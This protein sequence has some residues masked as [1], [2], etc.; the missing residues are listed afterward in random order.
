MLQSSGKLRKSV[1]IEPSTY[2]AWVA[3]FFIESEISNSMK[4]SSE[5]A[6]CL[7]NPK[8]LDNGDVRKYI[9]E[10]LRSLKYILRNMETDF[11]SLSEEC[12][13]E[14]VSYSA[15]QSSKHD[16]VSVTIP[17]PEKLLT[18]RDFPDSKPSKKRK[19]EF[20]KTT[21]SSLMGTCDKTIL[22][23]G[24]SSVGICESVDFT[25]MKTM[26]YGKLRE[27]AFTQQVLLSH[28]DSWRLSVADILYSTLKNKWTLEEAVDLLEEGNMLLN[29]VN[30][31]E[32][33][34]LMVV[35]EKTRQFDDKV[36]QTFGL[37]PSETL[38]N[39]Y[40]KIRTSLKPSITELEKLLKEAQSCLLEGECI[41]FLHYQ[42]SQL[43]SWKLTVQAA[44]D[45]KN[46][47]K[48]KD[49]IK[50][51]DEI[52]I[53]VPGAED[54]AEQIAASNWIEKVERA[55][56]RPMRLNVAENLLNE[57]AARYLD[58]KKVVAKK[59]LIARVCRARSWLETVL[60]PPFIYNLVKVLK[61]APVN[62]ISDDIKVQL[63]KAREELEAFEKI[64]EEHKNREFTNTTG[65]ESLNEHLSKPKLPTPSEFEQ[66]WLESS[67]LK[68]TIPIM[69]YMEPIY[70]R[71]RKWL[72]KYRRVLDGV[73]TFMESQLVLEEAQYTLCEYLDMNEYVPI[74]LKKVGE[75]EEW[76]KSSREF[77]Q[78][79]TD[80]QIGKDVE[81]VT[82][83]I[84]STIGAIKKGGDLS[85]D[86]I[87]DL[88]DDV[89]TSRL[90]KPSLEQ[91]KVLIDRGHDLTIYDNN[92]QE[93]YSSLEY[94]DKWT[95][96]AKE[97][98]R[99]PRESTLTTNAIASLLLDCRNIQVCSETEITLISELK[100]N[101]W[102][103]DVRNLSCP[104]ED[105]KLEDLQR[106]LDSFLFRIEL[107]KSNFWINKNLAKSVKKKHNRRNR[108][109]DN[110]KDNEKPNIDE[111]IENF[112]F[113]N[114]QNSPIHAVED[115]EI[116]EN[117]SAKL[118]KENFDQTKINNS[119]IKV[120]SLINSEE[121]SVPL[122]EKLNFGEYLE[123]YI[124]EEELCGDSIKVENT[125]DLIDLGFNQVHISE[126]TTRDWSEI[127][128]LDE[129]QFFYKLRD[130]AAYWESEALKLANTEHKVPVNK[131]QDL[132]KNLE[133]RP[134]R[135]YKI[136]AKICEYLKEQE[137]VR[138]LLVYGD[139][140][141]NEAMQLPHP[142]SLFYSFEKLVKIKENIDKLPIVIDEW[143]KW[144]I[145]LE[146]LQEIDK[147]SILKFPYLELYKYK[148]DDNSSEISG[149]VTSLPE[150]TKNIDEDFHSRQF[151]SLV[152]VKKHLEDLEFDISWGF[153]NIEYPEKLL[154]SL[155]A[156]RYL[157]YDMN[158]TLDWIEVVTNPDTCK[159]LDEWKELLNKG[160]NLRI[161]D[162]LVM[163][164][165]ESQLLE[166]E[167]WLEL[168][169]M[170]LH[171]K[172]SQARN[173]TSLRSRRQ[174]VS[175]VT[176][177]VPVKFSLTNAKKLVKTSYGLGEKLLQFRNLKSDVKLA[178]NLKSESIKLLIDS[179][180]ERRTNKFS[181]I[182]KKHLKIRNK[183]DLENT[184]K[185]HHLSQ[186]ENLYNEVLELARLTKRMTCTLA[187]CS[188]QFIL[189]D[190]MSYLQDELL[191]REINHK[192]L[193]LLL[194]DEYPY[195]KSN[196]INQV[197]YE[198]PEVVAGL[199][200][201]GRRSGLPISSLSDAVDLLS[202]IDKQNLLVLSCSDTH[203]DETD[204]I[205]S[206]EDSST[207]CVD[208]SD[209]DLATLEELKESFNEHSSSEVSDLS[210]ETLSLIYQKESSY[211]DSFLARSLQESVNKAKRWLELYKSFNFVRIALS[212]N[213]T[214]KLGQM[215]V[216][217][218][219]IPESIVTLLPSLFSELFSS[220][221]TKLQLIWSSLFEKYD[222]LVFD[223]SPQF[224]FRDTIEK[225]KKDHISKSHAQD[226]GIEYNVSLWL[227][228]SYYM[229]S[230]ER[231]SQVPDFDKE[232][233]EL[234]CSKIYS[235]TISHVQHLYPEFN[236][237]L[238]N[239]QT[240]QLSN[241]SSGITVG[242]GNTHKRQRR[243]KS[244][245]G[246]E[247]KGHGVSLSYQDILNLKERHIP[248][249]QDAIFLLYFAKKTVTLEIP[250]LDKLCGIVENIIL[251]NFLIYK[252]FP[253]LRYVSN[254]DLNK[255]LG[256]K[257]PSSL[258][259]CKKELWEHSLLFKISN[260]DIVDFGNKN[261]TDIKK[262][263][264][265][266]N[267]EEIKEFPVKS[268]SEVIESDRDSLDISNFEDNI[269]KMN[270]FLNIWDTSQ[271]SNFLANP[272]GGQTANLDTL[273]ELIEACDHLPFQIPLK[274]RLVGIFLDTLSWCLDA[275][276]AILLL[277]KNTLV[278]PWEDIVGD[279][280]ELK[281]QCLESERIFESSILYMN[282]SDISDS[283]TLD[284]WDNFSNQL[285][286][287]N[288]EDVEQ[289]IN[290][291]TIQSY[292]DSYLNGR[293]EDNNK[294]ENLIDYS[295]KRFSRPRGR[296][297]RLAN[298]N[299]KKISTLVHSDE[300]TSTSSLSKDKFSY[301]VCGRSLEESEIFPKSF[302][303]WL[304]KNPN[305]TFTIEDFMA[306]TL[307]QDTDK[308]RS[309]NK[310]GPTT[311]SNSHSIR[312]TLQGWR[313]GYFFS[314]RKKDPEINVMTDRNIDYSLY[315]QQV[316]MLDPNC[317]PKFHEY[318]NNSLIVYFIICMELYRSIQRTPADLCSICASF[319]DESLSS[320]SSSSWIACDECNRWYHQTCVGFI[321]LL[322][323]TD[324]NEDQNLRS[325]REFIAE[326]EDTEIETEKNLTSSININISWVCP[327][328]NLR[329]ISPNKVTPII[330]FLKNSEN[331][332][333]NHNSIYTFNS[334]SATE[335][336]AKEWSVEREVPKFERF[337][338]LLKESW[339]GSTRLINLYE[340][341]MILNRVTL[342]MLWMRDFYTKTR[343][344][345]F[346]NS[347]FDWSLFVD[348][349]NENKRTKLP[350]ETE[351][352]PDFDLKQV[353]YDTPGKNGIKL[354][355]KLSLEEYF[356]ESCEVG[357]SIDLADIEDIIDEVQTDI[358]Q[359]RNRSRRARISISA[360][361]LLNPKIRP[362]SQAPKRGCKRKIT[363]KGSS[364]TNVTIPSSNY[365]V[366]KS[367]IKI[368]TQ[369]DIQ[370][371]IYGKEL[372]TFIPDEKDK[373][374]Q[375]NMRK[376]ANP[377]TISEYRD[378]AVLYITGLL[379]GIQ[380]I[381][382]LQWSFEILRYLTFLINEFTQYSCT[383]AASRNMKI[384]HD[385]ALL[386]SPFAKQRLTW[387]HF[388][389]ILSYYS[390]KFPI[391][392][393]ESKKLLLIIPK[394][395]QY[396]E[397]C[398]DI[399][400]I[401]RGI[402][403][404]PDR[405]NQNPEISSCNSKLEDSTSTY[406]SPS[407]N[408]NLLEESKYNVLGKSQL[409]T[410]YRNLILSGIV[411]PEERTIRQILLTY[412]LEPVLIAFSNQLNAIKTN[413]VHPKPL[414]S[415]LSMVYKQIQEWTKE[416]LYLLET[417]GIRI[418]PLEFYNKEDTNNQTSVSLQIE[419]DQF[420]SRLQKFLKCAKDIESAMKICG[421]WNEKYKN[422]LSLSTEEE[423]FAEEPL[424]LF[425]N[426]KC[427]GRCDFEKCVELLKD[428]LNLP[429]IYP[430]VYTLGNMLASIESYED[431][432][433]Q[434]Y[435]N[436]SNSNISPTTNNNASPNA[437]SPQTLY[438]KF[439]NHQIMVS[440]KEYLMNLPIE[441]KDL[442][443]KL[444]N[445][446]SNLDKFIQLITNQTSIWKQQANPESIIT[447][448]QS[449]KDEAI[450]NVPI[451]V[452][453]LPELR[454]LV[455]NLPDFGSPHHNLLLR[456]QFLMAL[457]CPI[458]KIRKPL[459]PF[460]TISETNINDST[461][462]QTS[463]WSTETPPTPEILDKNQHQ[464]VILYN[465]KR[466]Y[467][468]NSDRGNVFHPQGPFLPLTQPIMPWQSI[469]NSCN[470]PTPRLPRND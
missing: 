335:R 318:M 332:L 434:V 295:K 281:Y 404:Y 32:Y 338:E 221:N 319:G 156:T 381:V 320:S 365:K 258:I 162:E 209:G 280:R 108:K 219:C 180:Q 121:N 356:G 439:E 158:L 328:C 237:C 191:L 113:V 362:I 366:T 399:V 50:D 272:E 374:I 286:L 35:I 83:N 238:M 310:F 28:I 1:R 189:I 315:I 23:E 298:G 140:E 11:N 90:K 128:R 41:G 74:L 256:S 422:M 445:M 255:G 466:R 463:K 225:F 231:G 294:E 252:K 460:P 244:T 453:N 340:R 125:E 264:Y 246:D 29:I 126:L 16:D 177:K 120:K 12:L 17:S 345:C 85:R 283:E 369:V 91:L 451:L 303:L 368:T 348:I 52:S 164:K 229:K 292:G 201:T 79:I 145:H 331:L 312:R 461:F 363:L 411:I 173:G 130:I 133:N 155:P 181:A 92:L 220:S 42:M 178:T 37:L 10:T 110:D 454:E 322:K 355:D 403:K 61:S 402:V 14:Y 357:S 149:P 203:S 343:W 84:W 242:T 329:A 89:S 325:S 350:S 358:R 390:P 218:N 54:L 96:R 25:S 336:R 132:L 349:L 227:N 183:K 376:L 127:S 435:I 309:Q 57:A 45:E 142:Q 360:K 285:T 427:G 18:K 30:L 288:I 157:I 34:E 265:L 114:T 72:K 82:S 371:L 213:R 443:V 406:T 234:F 423:E 135:M 98:L 150:F 446:Q 324:G 224:D 223:D 38:K 19:Y 327:L 193:S 103:V 267:I 161:M 314:L 106:S 240:Q 119:N 190:T 293:L 75:T 64:E 20:L 226:I 93:L 279:F 66:V 367:S 7:Y 185:D 228:L 311:L 254:N 391:I 236:S 65:I 175:N 387:D 163:N 397:K 172:S 271:Q 211:V 49:S 307:R 143:D 80:L 430:L 317:Y 33:Y 449:I 462:K 302:F 346:K 426:S 146:K 408:D 299:M 151:C 104:V 301:E 59:Q 419:S 51:K 417:Y 26:S 187:D 168:Y 266:V 377:R 448:L 450:Q 251:W 43:K 428:G 259:Y 15:S 21:D 352:E 109:T 282:T 160:K 77:L 165:F 409:E 115:T 447:Q 116:T 412:A 275:R 46:L 137:K 306:A 69:R 468:K 171:T 212:D 433:D 470:S 138:N 421:H 276:E 36:R 118:K 3:P 361:Q 457:Q 396:R 95:K 400:L 31:P 144:L 407:C 351:N 415:S 248:T 418:L 316:G 195:F 188:S 94:C 47:D 101:V 182:Y 105:F 393:P 159:S 48:C 204:E 210:H 464:D 250:E 395:K 241:N 378:L 379:I 239:E 424:D 230:M 148:V 192:M 372:N 194:I 388:Y 323:P 184:S 174:R 58:E 53:E 214:I 253:H 216:A 269:Q 373:E 6:K 81:Q 123:A 122:D 24:Y 375:I 326:S 102:K 465:T 186:K 257:F 136:E 347:L 39:R 235:S 305:T 152:E 384:Q 205:T 394:L 308:L 416:D 13:L 5:K 274:A 467:K 354:E 22:A 243:N 196:N 87:Q 112:G 405:I 179:Y 444:D 71:W 277:P 200:L 414:Y 99:G 370:Q 2:Q 62:D 68:M 232:F 207:Q 78:K 166:S 56:N 268:S 284:L 147:S 9:S 100:F 63:T 401:I 364:K 380:G 206:A 217:R 273:I 452:G 431:W 339:T 202:R 131:W 261:T 134:V 40:H 270:S 413:P 337:L 429:C 8:I 333:L 382:E 458:A 330:V 199:N 359:T 420:V 60:S 111:G 341:N 392:I 4:V 290:S 97:I 455:N 73:C 249:L 437:S 129:L 170:L 425:G 44:I 141:F 107:N 117:T 233:Y 198:P 278:R 27:L 456:T 398:K 222:N 197:K 262:E 297:K 289:T 459:S 296:P 247:L 67:S 260:F 441:K 287:D 70:Q 469:S 86:E 167:K 263:E 383:V 153:L 442:L 438:P 342:L 385:I 55:L 208:M 321:P 410:L 176:S 440:I 389:D 88:I 154:R 304:K 76:L 291:E 334:V 300:E 139:P 124:E 436:F 169:N 313:N 432:V 245:H 386:N 344:R 353:E 215:S